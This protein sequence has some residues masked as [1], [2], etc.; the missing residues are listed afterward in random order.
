MAT[1]MQA[2]D[3]FV[4]R[5]RSQNEQHHASH[6][7]SLQG[8]ASTVNHSYTSIGDHFV[9][10]YDRVHDI[11]EDISARTTAIQDSL[12]LSPP[13]SNNLS[14]SSAHPS[15]TPRSKN[16]FPQA[17]PLKRHNTNTQPRSHTPN[18]TRSSSSSTPSANLPPPPHPPHPPANPSSTPTPRPQRPLP[19]PRPLKLP[20]Q[21]R[22]RPASA[23]S[24]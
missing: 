14:Q 8:L 20:Q 4:S 7:Q 15:P 11:G 10:T 12:P 9:S 17:K 23:K 13:Q 24:T 22:P 2:L 19:L 18:P 16:T 6:L 1:Q 5:A 3:D 21:P